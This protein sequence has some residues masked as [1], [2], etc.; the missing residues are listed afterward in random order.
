M[1]PLDRVRAA[2]AGQLN[3]DITGF[4]L[5][6]TDAGG[7]PLSVDVFAGNARATLSTTDFRTRIGTDVVRSTWIRTLTVVP[8]NVI[9]EGAGRGHGVGL[10]Q[11]GCRAMAAG[12]ISAAQILAFYFPGTRIDGVETGGS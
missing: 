8:P 5:G 6:S 1:V 4:A 3:G 11:W 9:V 7:R 10:C 12:G 2:L